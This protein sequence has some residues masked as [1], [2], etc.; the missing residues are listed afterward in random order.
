M[1]S[2]QSWGWGFFGALIPDVISIYGWSHANAPVPNKTF[3]LWV[4]CVG[5]SLLYAVFAGYFTM[6]WKPESEAKAVW[7]GASFL[8][9]ASVLIK[10]APQLTK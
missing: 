10:N 6:A 3:G 9:I 7:L 4:L 1:T 5:A 2:K 8:T